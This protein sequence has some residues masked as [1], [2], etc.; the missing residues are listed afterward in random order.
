MASSTLALC[1]TTPITSTP[2]NL[3]C[4]GDRSAPNGGPDD[5]SVLGDSASAGY[6]ALGAGRT[7]VDVFGSIG[8]AGEA[9]TACA[10]MDNSSVKCWGRNNKGQL[11]LGDTANRGADATTMGDDLPVVDLGSN[12]ILKVV[13]GDWH[14][15]ALVNNGKMKCWGSNDFGQGARATS[16]ALGDEAGEMG[17][18]LP[19]VFDDEVVDVAAGGHTTCAIFKNNSLACWGF[20]GFSG[21]GMLGRGIPSDA[22][23]SVPEIVDLGGGHHAVQVAIGSQHVCALLNTSKVKCWGA[24]TRGQLGNG[25]TDNIGDGPDE[26]GENLATVPLGQ[27]AKFITAGSFH[28]CV[29]LTNNGVTCWGSNGNGQSLPNNPGSANLGDDGSD[30]LGTL[31]Q[32][33]DGSGQVDA[34]ELACGNAFSCARLSNQSVY[35]WGAGKVVDQYAT[36]N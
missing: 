20:N 26:M 23:S 16:Q 30:V 21:G 12:P 34:T 13:L 33:E 3:K 25:N 28:T 10:K 1:A 36:L 29:I 18:A 14:A 32:L 11:G 8:V 27:D 19:F 24:S 22:T 5:F 4:I 7:A 17:D 2:S 35:C 9:F 6:V 15:C 31:V